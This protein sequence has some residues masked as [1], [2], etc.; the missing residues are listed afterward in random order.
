MF[1]KYEGKSHVLSVPLHPSQRAAHVPGQPPD[2]QSEI[3]SSKASQ[4]AKAP[5]LTEPAKK[6]RFSM[7]QRQNQPDRSNVVHVVQSSSIPLFRTCA[8]NEAHDARS[9]KKLRYEWLVSQTR[10]SNSLSAL[11][12]RITSNPREN[13]KQCHLM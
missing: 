12:L 7:F 5:Q 8:I 2:G 6:L 13:P 4:M 11:E 10:P 9:P 1:A 3:V